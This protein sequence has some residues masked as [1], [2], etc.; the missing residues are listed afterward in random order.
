VSNGA[1]FVASDAQAFADYATTLLSSYPLRTSMAYAARQ[2]GMPDA[3]STIANEVER[4]MTTP[5]TRVMSRLSK[6]RSPQQHS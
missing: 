6:L 4:L 1:G 3:A 5:T 2:L